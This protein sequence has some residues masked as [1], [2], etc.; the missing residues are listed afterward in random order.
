MKKKKQKTIKQ[1]LVP[2]LKIN[3]GFLTVRL[4]IQNYAK[5]VILL[6]LINLPWHCR[7]YRGVPAMQIKFN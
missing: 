2:K 3:S 1:Y 5:Y 6:D 7:I 4:I